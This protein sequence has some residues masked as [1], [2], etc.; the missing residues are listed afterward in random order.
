[1]MP[2]SAGASAGACQG[3]AQYQRIGTR[4]QAQHRQILHG[5][6]CRHDPP[7]PIAADGC[8]Q[9]VGP[10]VVLLHRR[11]KHR[12]G[13]RRR[14]RR[15]AGQPPQAREPGTGSRKPAPRPDCP[16]TQAPES[17]PAART[18][19][20]CPAASQSARSPASCRAPSVPP[21][22]GRDHP[23][24]APRGDQHVHAG[25]RVGDRAN[26][27]LLIA[28]NRKDHRLPAARPHQRRQSIQL[29]L[30]MPPGG[31]GSPGMAISSPVARMPIRGRRCTESH[32]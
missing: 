28:G 29:E 17:R 12:H 19:A 31:I 9:M 3:A 2:T 14:R 20:V 25:N 11:A 1:M 23:P 10:P 30:T 26:R 22:P 15:Q 4:K 6:G 16:A 13:H 5:E 18:A 27:R 24:T 21:P 8:P 7:G 32:G